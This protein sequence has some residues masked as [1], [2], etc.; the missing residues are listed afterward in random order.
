MK[1]K[2]KFQLLVAMFVLFFPQLVLLFIKTDWQTKAIFLV[3]SLTICI[4]FFQDRIKTLKIDKTSFLLEFKDLVS[5]VN[6]T[7]DDLRETIQPIII[8]NLHSIIASTKGF[9]GINYRPAMLFFRKTL[10]LKKKLK[11]NSVELNQAIYDA[12]KAVII[13]ALYAIRNSLFNTEEC[14]MIVDN[15]KRNS[16]IS[17]NDLY[18]LKKYIYS[19]DNNHKATMIYTDLIEFIRETGGIDETCCKNIDR[20]S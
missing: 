16:G 7:L 13:L 10:A 6:A 18:D 5:A 20:D 1:K 9:S 17:E 15:I 19:I 3:C 11:L 8:L 2:D 12:R 4:L 14:I